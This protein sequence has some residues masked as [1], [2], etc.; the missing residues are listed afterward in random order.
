MLK[1]TNT[2]KDNLV[3]KVIFEDKTAIAESVIY[4]YK[5]RGVICFSVQS[6]CKVGCSFCGTGKKFIRN[7]TKEEMI[8]QI[9]DGIKKLP[10]KSKIQIMSM[11]MGEPTHNF[12][13]IPIKKYLDKGHYFFVSSVGTKSFNYKLIYDYAKKYEKFGFQFSLHHWNNNK[14]KK[15]LGNYEDLLDISE[16]I[17]VAKKYKKVSNKNLYFNYIATG[18][19][20]ILYEEKRFEGTAK[21]NTL[22]SIETTGGKIRV[23]SA[24]E[25]LW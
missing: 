12:N 21:V 9:E 17:N 22:E 19:E 14:R 8:L 24:R 7:L 13:E 3:E 1:I 5:D 23:G 6:G 11:S 25:L 18:K 10:N 16:L 4:S 2:F 20:T 15:L